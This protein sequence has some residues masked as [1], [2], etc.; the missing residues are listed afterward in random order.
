M[1][2]SLRILHKFTESVQ[3]KLTG[4]FILVLI[5]LVYVSLFTI[6][7]SQDILET[8]VGERTQG[9]MVSAMQY[10]DFILQGIEEQSVLLATDSNLNEILTSVHT[11]INSVSIHELRKAVSQISTVVNI[12]R[13]YS[14]SSILHGDS[15]MLISSEYGGIHV[16][17]NYRDSPWFQSVKAASGRTILYLP[18]EGKQEEPFFHKDSIT[19]LRTMDI[20]HVDGDK[21]ILMLSV[22]KDRLLDLVKNIN[23]SKNAVW[24]LLT[25][26]DRL[27]ASTSKSAEV[28]AWTGD[29]KVQTVT[30]PGSGQKLIMFRIKSSFSKW[31]I[32]LSQPEADLNMETRQLHTFTIAIIIA[33]G[34]FA[35]FI[36]GIFYTSLS[37]PLKKL[38]Q[39]MNQIQL[40][41]LN[42]RF[43]D[44]RRDEFGYLMNAYNQMAEK[45]KH[46]IENIYEQNLQVA[47]TEL[48]FLQSQINPH[49][50]YN[51]MDSIYW[52]SRNYEADEIGEM[53]LNLS[54][55]FRLSLEKGRETIPLSETFEHLHY[56]IRV[57]QLRFMD[58]F[59]VA[60]SLPEECRDAKVL[61][62]VVQPLVENAIIHGLEKK[63]AGGILRISA[64][65]SE[66]SGRSELN[67][68][69]FDNGK[70]VSSE[71]L[72]Y[73]QYVLGRAHKNRE[74]EPSGQAMFGLRNV[75]A[76]LELYYDGLAKLVI[77]SRE[78][79]WTRV[80]LRLPYLNFDCKEGRP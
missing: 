61:R 36:A 34:L 21:N 4:L 59:E 70:G 68:E 3:W 40:G 48:K 56:Y 43:R 75:Q 6:N 80:T 49:F 57:Q 58:R 45:Q 12:N 76:R 19:F 66:S 5:P 20:N 42:I 23:P 14:R 73:I 30:L 18:S 54:K 72:Q 29:H 35:L 25:G 15:N 77:D 55:F 60:Y 44:K 33:S 79:E 69:V 50:L 27:I 65:L 7:R 1:K 10:I 38:L 32:I 28:P 37:L 41:N 2:P 11:E 51:T 9:A 26:D 8:Q 13:Y 47:K 64:Y 31:S 17:S 24:Y 78:H 22:Q 46:L 52:M 71:R 67:I 53:V 62:L 39:G 16:E 74:F 63:H